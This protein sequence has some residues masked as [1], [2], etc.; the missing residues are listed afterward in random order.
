MNWSVGESGALALKA[1]RGAG[2][3]WGQA[4]EAAF[5]VRWLQQRGA[6]GIESLARYLAR[7]TAD[8]TDGCP[9][10]VGTA[11]SDTAIT[12]PADLGRIQEPLLVI[13]FIAS[14]ATSGPIRMTIGSAV[15]DVFSDRFITLNTLADLTASEGDVAISGSPVT[16]FQPLS[17]GSSARV[18]ESAEDAMAELAVLAS[19]T[20][21]PATDA[22]RAGA[23]SGMSD[24]D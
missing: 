23:G 3:S 1:A 19:N 7:F 17:E 9:L 5:A 11:L 12:P 6:P 13:P 15:V 10:S 20:Y 8:S 14:I 4:E 24:N 2:M 16:A 21:A 18:P 22:S